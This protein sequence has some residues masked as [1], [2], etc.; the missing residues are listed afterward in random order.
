M[1]SKYYETLP[2]T[3]QEQIKHAELE[4]DKRNRVYPYTSSDS[5]IP[6]NH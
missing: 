3:L 5:R 6:G 1:I 2:V 4:Y